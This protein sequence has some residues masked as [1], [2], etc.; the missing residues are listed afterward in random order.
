MG[1][2]QSANEDPRNVEIESESEGEED[3]DFE[4]TVTMMNSAPGC[5]IVNQFEKNY[6]LTDEENEMLKLAKEFEQFLNDRAFQKDIELLD[7]LAIG[8]YP[9]KI[10]QR[11]MR[12]REP[13]EPLTDEREHQQQEDQEVTP[14]ELELQVEPKLLS[15]EQQLKPVE[16]S[17]M[18]FNIDNGLHNRALEKTHQPQITVEKQGTFP[19]EETKQQQPDEKPQYIVSPFVGYIFLF[20]QWKK[21]QQL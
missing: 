21:S 4:P 20:Q 17:I 14:A 11:K 10:L 18:N 1:A 6:I 19:V 15:E 9:K 5:I 16:N 8:R 7:D 2:F 13:Q 3:V 12:Q